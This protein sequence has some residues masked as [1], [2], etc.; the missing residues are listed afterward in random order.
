MREE[1]IEIAGLEAVL[2]EPSAG[3]MPRVVLLHGY[4]MQARD[5]SPFA[6]SL[7]VVAR[8]LVP[9]GPEPARGAGRAWWETDHDARARALAV[10]PRDLSDLHPAGVADARSRFVA[11]LD[12]ARGR[13]GVAPTAVIGFSQ[14][15]MLACDAVFR[16]D[17]P[18]TL[19]ALAL[20]ST[21]CL[22]RD[23]WLPHLARV[24]GL[25]VLVSHGRGD[26]DLS[27]AAGERLRDTMAQGGAQVSWV[28]GDHGHEIPFPVWRALRRFL[29]M[30]I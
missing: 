13:W 24:A 27:F 25:P 18:L 22:G 15:G 9:N 1:V 2:V 16:S 28:P 11:L 5:L 23:A 26:P 29:A 4:G 12:A 17:P 6:R 19:T 30:W 8:F 21:S 20:L 7:G 14:G 3:P 10:G